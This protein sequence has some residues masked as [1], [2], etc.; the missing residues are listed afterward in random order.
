MR[1]VLS[2]LFTLCVAGVLAQA[3]QSATPASAAPGARAL[4]EM[5]DYLLGEWVGEASGEPGQGAG[6]ATF[7]ASL[8][9]NIVM[10]R[11]RTDFPATGG[12]PAIHHVDLL[13]IYPEGGLVKADYFDN[14]GHVIHYEVAFAHESA[15]LTFTSP[16]VEGQPR[17]RLTYRPLGKD[18]VEVSFDLAPPG[19]PTAFKT[20]VKG[21][22]RRK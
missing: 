9:G 22:S 14:E 21:V 6:S 10:R 18:R 2:V 20:H 13:V 12:N 7:E 11:S 17:Q 3:Q 4:R 19:Q 8:D 5:T 1:V 16:I 15:T